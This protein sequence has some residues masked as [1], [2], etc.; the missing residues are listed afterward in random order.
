VSFDDFKTEDGG[1]PVDGEHTAWLERTS[2]FESRNGQWFIRTCWRTTDLEHYWETL[3]GTEG[4]GKPRTQALMNALG[5]DLGQLSSWDALG[6]ELAMV[7]GRAYHVKVTH[8][9][10]FVNT[11]VIERSQGVQDELRPDRADLP[12]PEP[13]DGQAAAQAVAAAA[14]AADLFGDDVPF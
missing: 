12:D 3:N 5:I 8:R 13:A 2:V 1:E 9:G 6:D 10:E 7:E 4:Q 11:A 14:R